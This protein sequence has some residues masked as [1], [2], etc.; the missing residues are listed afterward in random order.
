MVF[1]VY[2]EAFYM[3]SLYVCSLHQTGDIIFRE[4]VFGMIYIVEIFPSFYKI[5]TIIVF[6]QKLY[7]SCSTGNLKGHIELL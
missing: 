4:T 5:Q 3:S 1:F 7:H 6:L 2:F